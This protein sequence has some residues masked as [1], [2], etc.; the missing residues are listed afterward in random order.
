[1]HTAVDHNVAMLSKVNGLARHSN[2]NANI[3]P[4]D[5]N[6]NKLNTGNGW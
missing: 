6:L 2:Q 1:M 5:K 3:Q 4:R